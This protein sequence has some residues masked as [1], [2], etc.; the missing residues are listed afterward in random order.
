MLF[1]IFTIYLSLLPFMTWGGFYEGPKILYFLIG[2]ILLIIFWIYRILVKK[3]TFT[4][5]KVDYL[6]LAWLLILLVGSIFGIHPIES[7]LGGSYRHQ[8][9][10]FFFTLWLIYKTV[11]ISKSKEEKFLSRCLGVSVFLESVIVILQFVSGNLYLGKPLGTLGEANAV[12]G[13]LAM[14]Y[15]F[16][17]ENFDSTFFAIPIIAI[18]IAESRSGILSL[19]PSL[20]ILAKK[21]NIKFKK[22]FIVSIIILGAVSIFFISRERESSPFENRQVIWKLGFQQILQRPILG[23]GAESG[24]AVYNKAFYKYGFPLSN[25]IIDRAHNLFLDIALWSGVPGLIIFLFFIFQRFKGIK[26]YGR[27]LAFISFLVYSMFQPL[28]VAHYLFLF[29]L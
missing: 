23:F 12:A 4:F 29:L 18:L 16:V 22:I 8:G 17:F 5:G 25:L 28:P 7:I 21:I 3:K 14:G 15:V 24:E 2:G 9:V 11:E 20:L 26:N 6:Y 1:Q 13:F 19:L 27:K 10:I